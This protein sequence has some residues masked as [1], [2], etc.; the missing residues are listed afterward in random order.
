MSELYKH[1][2]IYF[3]LEAIME[4][5]EWMVADISNPVDMDNF[6]ETV[7][8]YNPDDLF[9]GRKSLRPY[10]RSLLTILRA[11]RAH[12]DVQLR[13]LILISDIIR[14]KPLLEEPEHIASIRPD[15]SG[16]TAAWWRFRFGNPF[17]CFFPSTLNI[18]LPPFMYF[19]SFPT[20][21]HTTTTVKH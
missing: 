16:T 21:H 8:G 4:M 6:L 12:L 13:R 9:L 10:K 15:Y 1:N 14:A 20:P 5:D 18:L 2:E 3:D 19:C 11:R 7:G 17:I